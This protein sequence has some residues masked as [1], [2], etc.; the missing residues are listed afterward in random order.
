MLC[1]IILDTLCISF[2][3]LNGTLHQ[4][5]KKKKR[6]ND[7]NLQWERDTKKGH[8]NED[9]R[10]DRRDRWG[11]S[12]A[13]ARGGGISSIKADARARVTVPLINRRGA[14]LSTFCHANNF[15][16][17]PSFLPFTAKETKW[18]TVLE[19]IISS[20]KEN[21]CNAH[22]ASNWVDH[23]RH[24]SLACYCACAVDLLVKS[25]CTGTMEHTWPMPAT[26][27]C[28]QDAFHKK[29]NVFSASYLQDA[30]V[31][32]VGHSPSY[33]L[34]PFQWC[35]CWVYR[36]KKVQGRNRP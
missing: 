24:F 5:K 10:E 17:A 22:H 19:M 3:A 27:A 33:H 6:N 28:W 4:K 1:G 14:P 13:W 8:A 29:K 15:A 31:L 20:I 21:R 30:F 35:A 25:S 2:C 26:L 18:P 9:R 12:M 32:Q 11:E 23:T 36:R 7:A 16:Y 34:F